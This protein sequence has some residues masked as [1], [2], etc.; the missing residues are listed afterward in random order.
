MP[1]RGF[2][3][4]TPQ[5]TSTAFAVFAA[6][7]GWTAATIGWLAFLLNRRNLRRLQAEDVARWHDA[8]VKAA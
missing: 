3:Q 4:I 7:A 8:F 2:M 1:D 5:V 6:A